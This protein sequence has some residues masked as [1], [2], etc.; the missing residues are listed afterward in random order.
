PVVILSG[1][2]R[3]GA[4]YNLSYFTPGMYFSFIFMFLIRRRYIMWWTKYNYILS[5]G[6]TAG[7][8]FSGILI[9]F[10][11]QYTGHSLK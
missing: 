7:M 4:T 5:S 8:A 1:I 9:F 3:Y 6:L 11:F 10:A 2:T